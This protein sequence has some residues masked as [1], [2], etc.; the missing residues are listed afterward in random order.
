MKETTGR[1]DAGKKER[2]RDYV[3]GEVI[4]GI[5]LSTHC[6]S[7]NFLLSEEIRVQSIP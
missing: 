6:N 2:E 5:L 3:R 7:R 1:K 4:T